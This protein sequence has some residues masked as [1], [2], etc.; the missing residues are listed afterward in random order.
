[1]FARVITS[2]GKKYLNIINGYRDSDGKVKQ[3]VI[4]NLGKVDE[5]NK[6]SIEKIAVKLL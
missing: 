5:L 4:A 2:R 6:T 1:M 3:K